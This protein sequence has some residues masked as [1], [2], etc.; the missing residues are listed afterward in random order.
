MSSNYLYSRDVLVIR[1]RSWKSSAFFALCSS[2]L[3]F[4]EDASRYFIDILVLFGFR[5]L[6]TRA[7]GSFLDESA[8]IRLLSVSRFMRVSTNALEDALDEPTTSS[9]EIKEKMAGKGEVGKDGLLRASNETYIHLRDDGTPPRYTSHE[10]TVVQELRDSLGR[11]WRDEVGISFRTGRIIF[12]AFI[13]LRRGWVARVSL[14][15]R[16]HESGSSLRDVSLDFLSLSL[17]YSRGITVTA[18]SRR[19][20]AC[21]ATLFRWAWWIRRFKAMI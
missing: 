2:H 4:S 3:H 1:E 19:D 13:P 18:E 21:D 6:I 12:L 5:A 8:E 9:I 17:T 15:P 16:F 10:Y 14:S 20:F 11:G 7:K